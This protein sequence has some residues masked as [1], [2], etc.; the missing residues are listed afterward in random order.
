MRAIERESYSYNPFD[1]AERLRFDAATVT[2]IKISPGAP[3]YGIWHMK[4]IP[5]LLALALFIP[6]LQAHR[7]EV[8]KSA[9]N[10]QPAAQNQTSPPPGA[11]QANEAV[12]PAPSKFI[13]TFAGSIGKYAVHMGLER[14]GADLDGGYSY[15]R[16]GGFSEL[17]TVLN[18]KG[19]IDRA[20][21]V[22]L[23]ETSFE[24]GNPHDTGDFKGKLDGL[25]VN[26]DVSLRFSGLWTGKDGKQ[27]PFSLR[28]SRFDLGGLK[29]VEKKNKIASKK[30]RYEIEI[31]APQ[32]AGAAPALGEKFDQ[33]VANLIAARTSEFKKD[34][35]DLARSGGVTQNG[36]RLEVSYETKAADKD[37][38]SLLFSFEVDVVGG[39]PNS[40]HESLN[41]DLN[42]N[43]RVKLA[44]L[45]TPNSNYLNVISDYSIKEFKKLG[46]DHT[47]LDDGPKIENFHS[48]NITSYGLDILFDRGQIISSAAGEFEV[49]VP[50]LL[51]KP[52][53]KPDGLLGQFAK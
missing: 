17:A 20:G 39:R 53:I 24:N 13:A 15:E 49:V 10:T 18:L 12:V 29:I 37:F 48:W 27:L 40:Y 19:R 26:G 3:E 43:E 42:R 14:N 25:S 22:T 52:I 21:N 33:A 1:F 47:E 44:D 9:L 28:E 46:M 7:S 34:A 41:Y 5:C 2:K 31:E 50:Y 8:A 30:L 38:I 51:L 23:T 11:P 45:F 32:L 16:V 36:S 35:A 6:S 4:K